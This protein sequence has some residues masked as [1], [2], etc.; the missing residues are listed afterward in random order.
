MPLRCLSESGC[1][2]RCRERIVASAAGMPTLH[3]SRP[4]AAQ[5]RSAARAGRCNDFLPPR[6]P[7]RQAICADHSTRAASDVATHR[8][9]CNG[10]W[11]CRTAV[12]PGVPP[13]QG[14]GWLDRSSGGR[15]RK[16]RWRRE[17]R[18]R[19]SLAG[20][21]PAA[22]ENR[23]HCVPAGWSLASGPTEH[24]W[25]WLAAALPPSVPRAQEAWPA[26]DTLSVWQLRVSTACAPS[27][28]T[29]ATEVLQARPRWVAGGETSSSAVAGCHA[30]AR[31]SRHADNL[32]SAAQTTA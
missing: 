15:A 13:H 4:Q 25:P 23:H 27:S 5:V 11:Q 17:S 30:L 32:S 10:G 18:E 7:P 24:D 8:H 12:V 2:W 29:P 9:R 19:Y 3:D 21:A 31:P 22:P 20:L 26:G 1:A 14:P 16:A 6:A 28:S